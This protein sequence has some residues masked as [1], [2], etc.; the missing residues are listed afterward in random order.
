N[1]VTE[2]SL[3]S[4]LNVIE[5]G[6]FSCIAIPAHADRKK[7]LL[8]VKEGTQKPVLDDQTLIQAYESKA[9]D[10]IEVK[11]QSI[12]K[13]S[14]YN[15]RN[16]SW[17]EVVG[18][19]CHNFK[20]KSAP[21]SRYTWVKMETP[22][23]ESLKLALL[24]GQDFSIKRDDD[25]NDFHPF[26][27]P[28]FFIESINIK[29]AKYMGLKKDGELLKFSP[30][31]NSIVGG[32]GT[33]KSTITHCLRLGSGR[34]EELEKDTTSDSTFNDFCKVSKQRNEP[35]ALKESTN[36]KIIYRRF[37]ERYLLEFNQ[38]DGLIKVYEYVDNEWKLS[39]DQSLDNDRFPIDLYSQGQIAALVGNNNQPLIELID[40]SANID[41][42]EL[43]SAELNF[44]A[45]RA[46]MRRLKHQKDLVPSVSRQLEDTRKKIHRLS[47]ANNKDVLQRFDEFKKQKH[48]LEEKRQEAINITQ[49]Y[50]DFLYTVNFNLSTSNDPNMGFDNDVHTYTN[51]LSSAVGKT[52]K[53]SLE[54]VANLE[55]EISNIDCILKGSAWTK[56]YEIA[57]NAYYELQEKFKSEGLNNLDEYEGLISDEASIAKQL[58]ELQKAEH[59]FEIKLQISK[60]LMLKIQQERKSIT[61]KRQVFLSTTLVNNPYVKIEIVPFGATPLVTE[62]KFRELLSLRSEFANDIYVK[63]DEK[64]SGIIHEFT[65]AASCTDESQRDK[66]ISNIQRKLYESAKGS[67]SDYFSGFFNNKLKQLDKQYHD[68][69][70]S[71][72][73]W[74]PEDG[75]SVEYSRKGDGTHFEP[76]SQ[77]SAGQRAA[78]M[79]AF[80]LA[81][82]KK[83][84]FIDQPEDD[85]DNSLIYDMIVTQIKNTKSTRQI[86][87]VTHNP[88]I[89]V[90]GDAEMVH[91]LDF[92][93]QCYVK[94]AGSIQQE[95]MRGAICKIMEGG[96]IAFNHRYR[97]LN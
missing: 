22:C 30:Y 10:A 27:T 97:R 62:K 14:S 71:L 16:M 40:R 73:F 25:L 39:N 43:A 70:D 23:L 33:G 42:S 83:P 26:K 60:E 37:D 76:I 74:Y 68:F 90:N 56:N 32:R 57:T 55:S 87:T 11:S 48:Y 64:T 46:D 9:I 21:G 20:D 15:E 6:R 78:A 28:D 63:S 88:N 19:D 80:L 50:K 44:S 85:L 84:L 41:T 31:S 53:E 89:V 35:G 79:L 8:E 58:G 75:L 93:N 4:I 5:T 67:K 59:D 29:Q 94:D 51:N 82:S 45:V 3:T 12:L 2:M 7:G 69:S 54:L 18:S 96:K 66:L 86:I 65:C 36:I 49:Q 81:H 77:G 17:T 91:A 52:K 1:D 34:G 95:N 13:P 47:Q 72:L 24:D 92:N 38:A 61:N